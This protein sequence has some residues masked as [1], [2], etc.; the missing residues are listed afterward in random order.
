VRESMNSSLGLL[1]LEQ[2]HERLQT[3]SLFHTYGAERFEM[4]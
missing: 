3:T 2:V 1:A 4:F